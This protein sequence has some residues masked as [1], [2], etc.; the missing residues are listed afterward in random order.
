MQRLPLQNLLPSLFVICVVYLDDVIHVFLGQVLVLPPPAFP[1]H[2]VPEHL[3][4]RKQSTLGIFL[5]GESDLLAGVDP[6]GALAL[7]HHRL[8]YGRGLSGRRQWER[9]VGSRL[10]VGRW[11][12]PTKKNS[13][14]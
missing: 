10:L 9:L 13:H 12:L 1:Q 14:S 7:V 8:G 4:K 6:V 3:L 11:H 5:E 2:G